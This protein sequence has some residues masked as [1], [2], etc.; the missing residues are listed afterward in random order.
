MA[1]NSKF[2]SNIKL[3]VFIIPILMVT[4][5]PLLNLDWIYT[6]SQ[7]EID[8]NI[9]IFG[10]EKHNQIQSD[11]DDQFTRWFIESGAY[12]KSTQSERSNGDSFAIARTAD[13][14]VNGYFANLW[15]MVYRAQ[16]R[17][18]VAW[19]WLAGAIILIGASMYDG[20]QQRNIKRHTF[21]YSN[22]LAFHLITHGLLLL[23]GL[24][25][26]LCF[27]PMAITPP[28]WAIGIVAMA[29]LG[30]KM[31]ESFQTGS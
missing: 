10:E 30:W 17:L 18:N 31:M 19:Q 12:G 11:T 3:W 16:Y 1:S 15:K 8:S 25:I 29:L 27:F 26:A 7:K 23:I 6:I 13:G 20:W 5:I 24:S 14:F 2:V 28:A 22:P 9:Y 4:I 21:G